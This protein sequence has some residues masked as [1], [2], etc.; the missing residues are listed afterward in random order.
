MHSSLPDR[1]SE[2]GV[3]EPQLK[4]RNP[5]TLAGGGTYLV[6]ALEELPCSDT[7]PKY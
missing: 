6:S 2:E 5:A 7:R 1:Y 4:A 3:V